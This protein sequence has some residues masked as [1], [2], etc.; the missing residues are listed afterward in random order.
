MITVNYIQVYNWVTP[1][2]CSWII[3]FCQQTCIS[4]MPDNFVQ[5]TQITTGLDSVQY[6]L[7][8][9]HNIRFTYV[10]SINLGQFGRE[11]KTKTNICQGIMQSSRFL[12]QP[13]AHYSIL[14]THYQ[15]LRFKF[16]ASAESGFNLDIISELT[17]P[18]N[19]SSTFREFAPKWMSQNTF[20]DKP[21]LVQ[22]MA[23]CCWKQ[24]ITWANV[25]PDMA[26]LNH[27]E[28][29]AGHPRADSRCKLKYPDPMGRYHSQT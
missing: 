14:P 24:T 2:K 17:L 26:P 21:T 18:V 7:R 8:R 13:R 15:K 12:L 9:K 27:N 11:A 4:Q 1:F 23:W 22:V 3:W 16:L 6:L 29:R 5:I 25:D 20:D 28:F 10:V 19:N